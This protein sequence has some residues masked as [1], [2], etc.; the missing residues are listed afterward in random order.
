MINQMLI[1]ITLHYYLYNSY[2]LQSKQ[3]TLYTLT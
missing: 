1:L 2:K 3:I